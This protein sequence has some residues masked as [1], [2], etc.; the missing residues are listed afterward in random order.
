MPQTIERNHFMQEVYNASFKELP[1]DFKPLSTNDIA[2]AEKDLYKTS[3]MPHQEPG[4]RDSCALPYEL[5]V[6]GQ[7]VADMN[8]FRIQFT[9]ADTFFGESAKGAPFNVYAPGNYKQEMPD[10]SV[11]YLAVQTWPF[12]VGKGH[13]L[14]YEWPLDDFEDE[15]YHL[16]VYGP[17]GFYREFMGKATDP[18]LQIKCG[19]QKKRGF[20]KKLSGNIEIQIANTS[21]K[22]DMD[23]TVVDHAYGNPEQKIRIKKGAVERIVVSSAKSYGWYDFSLQLPTNSSFV[24]RYAGRVET[25]EASKS[26][27]FMGRVVS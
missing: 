25:G 10:G 2:N 7:V 8:L 1:K 4:I 12:A 11:D 22:S 26:D 14:D 5:Y 15:G 23:I 19:Y 20:I 24:R 6:D 21:K 17:N 27:P 3:F 16:R 9:A 18:E 13:S